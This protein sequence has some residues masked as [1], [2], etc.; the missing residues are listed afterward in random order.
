MNSFPI[1]DLVEAGRFD[2]QVFLDPKYILLTPEIT[3]GKSL[4]KD[5]IQWE[6]REI[7]TDGS[8]R[9]PKG[10]STE[11]L[12]QEIEDA[13]KDREAQPK[14]EDFLLS[15]GQD[16]EN[17]RKVV[18]FYQRFTSFVDQMFTKYVTRNDLNLQEISNK[19][20]ELCDYVRDNRRFVLRIQDSGASNRNYLVSHAVKTTILSIVLGSYLKLQPHKLIELGVAALLHEIGMVRLPP[21]L[22]MTDKPL[23]PQ[24]KKN[25]FSHPV[26][27][28]NILREF[29]FPLSIC[30]ASLEHHERNNGHGYPRNL[31]GDKISPYAKIIAVACSYDA[32]TSSRPYKQA[33]DGY[34]G[35]VDMLKNEGKQYEENVIRALVYSLSIYP[36]GTYVL[37]SDSRPALVVDTNLS[38][39][40]FPVVNV[41]G[42]AREDGKTTFLKTSP[43][44]PTVTRIL[45]Q[46]EVSSI[47]GPR[48]A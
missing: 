25:I 3:V 18:E 6:F 1:K 36:I 22:Y 2:K 35:M 21:Q 48:R 20:K 31:S 42:E 45:T 9:D 37:L 14:S 15:A 8:Q 29:S 24:E 28:Y 39:P 13:E 26:F 11:A 17:L 41:V 30:L 27:G 40:R 10:I 23:S 4:I 16:R 33:K 7:L 44:G 38:D 32:V 5:L 12:N 46:E 19:V 34:S 43:A 47:V